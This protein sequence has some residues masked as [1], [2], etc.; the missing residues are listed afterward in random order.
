M[1]SCKIQTFFLAI[2]KTQCCKVI[3]DFLWTICNL[4][5]IKNHISN[6]WSNFQLDKLARR[7][8]KTFSTKITKKIVAWWFSLLSVDTLGFFVPFWHTDW[9]W[10]PKLQSPWH[11]DPILPSIVHF[12]GFWRQPRIPSATIQTIWENWL[13]PNP[14]A[15]LD[16]NQNWA[17]NVHSWQ[18]IQ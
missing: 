14:A 3:I 7:K 4:S 17:S 13:W 2:F 18:R 16:V 9:P 1:Q 15:D 6:A 5:V 11:Y 8:I 12:L 10:W